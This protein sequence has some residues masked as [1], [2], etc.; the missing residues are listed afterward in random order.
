MNTLKMFLFS[1]TLLATLNFAIAEDT[2]FDNI[3]GGSEEFAY[4]R[5]QGELLLKIQRDVELVCEDGLCTLFAVDT[6][7]NE[8]SVEFDIGYGDENGY[9]GDGNGV[10]ILPDGTNSSDDDD[11]TPFH[12]GF[13]AKYSI[14]NC[15]QEVKVPETLYVSMNVFLA[16]LLNTDGTARRGFT[17]ADEAMIMFYTTIMKQANGCK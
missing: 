6:D 7:F 10:I 13:K 1:L 16:G 9:Y 12:V 17:P 5:N 3:A 8:F 2:E 14:G 4:I 11:E 15:K